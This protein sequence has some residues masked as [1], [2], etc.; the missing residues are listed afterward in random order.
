MAQADTAVEVKLC[1]KC[2]DE[3]PV[4]E[5]YWDAARTG[6][7]PWCK[8]CQRAD[9]RRR[10]YENQPD[11]QTGRATSYRIRYGIT[12]ED[13]D[14]ML[15]QQEGGC[16]ICRREP[17]LGKYLSVDHDHETGKVRALLCA[18]CNGLV[19]HHE[20]DVDL[21]AKIVAYVELHRG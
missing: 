17:K 9:T 11:P 7:Y 10:Y 13:Y 4:D 18:R 1:T 21:F 8:E 14:R 5:F 12:I 3:K 2:G 20:K 19:G 6:P 15:E 16:A